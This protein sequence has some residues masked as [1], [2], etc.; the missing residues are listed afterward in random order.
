MT[1]IFLP[2]DRLLMSAGTVPVYYWFVR[3]ITIKNQRF[4]RQFLIEFEEARK[5]NRQLSNEDPKS[6]DV[7][8][9]LIEFDNLNRSTNDQ[10]SHEGRF[11][12]L[13]GRFA[14]YVKQN[15]RR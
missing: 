15:S 5:Q 10:I 1:E 14:K 2:N 13:A 12:I 8:R 11:R 9:Q 3:S 7:D 4:V 6:R